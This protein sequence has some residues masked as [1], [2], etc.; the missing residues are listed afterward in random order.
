MSCDSTSTHLHWEPE[1][2]DSDSWYHTRVLQCKGHHSSR[3]LS[4]SGTSYQHAYEWTETKIRL[5]V[6]STT[7]Q[8]NQWIMNR[9]PTSS[10]YT[11]ISTAAIIFID[12]H[13]Y[14]HITSI[15]MN[16]MLDFMFIGFTELRRSSGNRTHNLSHRKLTINLNHLIT[17]SVRCVKNLMESC[18]I[19]YSNN[20]QYEIDYHGLMYRHIRLKTHFILALLCFYW[21]YFAF[22]FRGFRLY[23]RYFAFNFRVFHL[24]SRYFA[25]D[26]RVFHLY[27]RYFAFDIRVH[28]LW[29]SRYFA[30]DFFVFFAFDF[31]SFF[32]LHLSFASF[33]L[34]CVISL[35]PENSNFWYQEMCTT[36]SYQEIEFLISRN[37]FF[38]IKNMIFLISRNQFLISRNRILGRLITPGRAG[39]RRGYEISLLHLPG[40]SS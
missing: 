25:F 28:R 38:D 40:Y 22:D 17:L 21:R 11:L 1:A 33:V 5:V 14:A 30:F 34:N 27:S 24:Y 26:F 4:D 10:Y 3:R 9:A 7:G 35:V 12:I 19:N 36:P 15:R 16:A 37:T 20:W 2:T 8:C 29:L 32:F 6:L 39:N 18:H 13:P 31:R 23:L